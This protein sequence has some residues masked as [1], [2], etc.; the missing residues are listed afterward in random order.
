MAKQK[1]SGSVGDAPKN[2][3]DINSD[4]TGNGTYKGEITGI[5]GTHRLLVR[6]KP[7]GKEKGKEYFVYVF[8]EKIQ[9]I[10]DRYGKQF[11]RDCGLVKSD[12]KP[13]SKPSSI[14]YLV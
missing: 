1:K 13:K 3:N 7:F 12:P 8:P 14:S 6:E 11:V 9:A 2:S 5:V 10:I 4:L